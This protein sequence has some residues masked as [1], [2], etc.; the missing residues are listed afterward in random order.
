MQPSRSAELFTDIAART[1][2]RPVR[3]AFNRMNLK[4][5]SARLRVWHIGE[6]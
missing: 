6:D 1:G 3:I 4:N 2:I 5:Q